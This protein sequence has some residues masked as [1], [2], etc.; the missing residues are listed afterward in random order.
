MLDSGLAAVVAE[1]VA[2][3]TGTQPPVSGRRDPAALDSRN[4]PALMGKAFNEAGMR[5]V[6]AAALACCFALA[7]CVP[8]ETPAVQIS[9]P[10][11]LPAAPPLPPE[12]RRTAGSP[13][14]DARF[15]R[16]MDQF[17]GACGALQ[18]YVIGAKL[19]GSE[20]R[21]GLMTKAGIA[22]DALC[23]D[24]PRDIETAVARAA[25]VYAAI[26]SPRFRR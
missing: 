2:S 26:G 24:P 6:F 18:A 3:A 22:L 14:T 17:A 11:A 10:V 25:E 12:P 8:A 9:A 5:R 20:K 15:A 1:A 13:I 19:F 4:D 16:A 21:R 7:A 23:S